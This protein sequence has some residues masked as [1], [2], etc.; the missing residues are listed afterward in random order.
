MTSLACLVFIIY[1]EARS[2]PLEV[3]KLVA[4]VVINRSIRDNTSICD[5]IKRGYENLYRTKI[6]KEEL[7]V[8]FKIHQVGDK[9]LK[10]HKQNFYFYFNNKN[11]G[12]RFKSKVK[13]IKTEK[14]I[15]Y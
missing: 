4:Q 5:S 7:D 10:T 14:L 8:L 2:E 13:P 9:V 1:H 6:N 12:V 15:F 3:Q 11:L